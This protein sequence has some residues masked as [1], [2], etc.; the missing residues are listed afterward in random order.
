MD[1]GKSQGWT[2]LA[3]AHTSDI[4]NLE[5]EMKRVMERNLSRMSSEVILFCYIPAS[6]RNLYCLYIC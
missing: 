3:L 6:S 1:R 5:N 2:C 4:P